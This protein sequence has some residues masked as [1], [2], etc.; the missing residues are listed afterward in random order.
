MEGGAGNETRAAALELLERSAFFEDAEVALEDRQRWVLM[1]F[2]A[3]SRRLAAG[4]FNL[5]DS[6]HGQEAAMAIRSLAEYLITLHWLLIDFEAHDL[7][8]QI[9]DLR[10]TL[11]LGREAAR[12]GIPVMG[13]EQEGVFEEECNRLRA[14]LDG[15]E[16]IDERVPANKRERM[17][18]FE[19]RALATG[20]GPLYAVAYRWDSLGA[21]HPNATALQQLLERQGEVGVIRREPVLPLPHPYGVGASLLALVLVKIAELYEDLAVPGLADVAQRIPGLEELAADAPP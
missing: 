13:A 2:G 18:G 16:N 15:L 6:G 4:A 14:R 3:R 19:E 8:W 1:L 20:L 12:H 9:D 17:P 5:A 11:T 10:A 21:A 7:V